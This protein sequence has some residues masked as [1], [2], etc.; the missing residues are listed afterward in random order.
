MRML[1]PG[2]LDGPPE[3]AYRRRGARTFAVIR[4]INPVCKLTLLFAIRV[5]YLEPRVVR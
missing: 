1:S 3:H 4:T 5:D 2:R